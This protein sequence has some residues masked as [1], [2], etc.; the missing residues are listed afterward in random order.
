VLGEV[1]AKRSVIPKTASSR[2]HVDEDVSMC[3]PC[4]LAVFFPVLNIM[5]SPDC[6]GYSSRRYMYLLE[7]FPDCAYVTYKAHPVC[8]LFPEMPG[9]TKAFSPDGNQ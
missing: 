4:D 5:F 6:R 3:T 2:I 7:N 9:I 1:A 8:K